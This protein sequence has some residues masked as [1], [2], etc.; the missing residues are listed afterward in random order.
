[1]KNYLLLAFLIL[2]SALTPIFG[3]LTVEEISPVSLGFFRFSVACILFLITLKFRKQ[4][5]KFEK[6]DYPK[7]VIMGVLSIPINQF[8]FLNGVNLSYASH[9]GIIYSLNPVFAYLISVARKTEKFYV[10]KMIAI[11]LTIIG[12]FFVL[13]KLISTG[14]IAMK[15]CIPI[16]ARV[17][18]SNN[19]LIETVRSA[20][21]QG[22]VVR[23]SPPAFESYDAGVHHIFF[24]IN[25]CQVPPWHQPFTPFKK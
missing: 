2:A 25:R 16:T 1:M 21:G 18:W 23:A 15:P 24:S 12:I 9:S 19:Q 8:F 5:L 13:L 7:L 11:L 20:G 22:V 4:N 3:K 6:S 14:T 17:V 10:S